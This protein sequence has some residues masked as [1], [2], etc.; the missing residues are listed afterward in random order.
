MKRISWSPRSLDDLEAL[1]EFIADDSPQNTELVRCRILKAVD[2][3]TGFQFGQEGPIPG[4][5][6]LYIQKTSYFLIYRFKGENE[7]EVVAFY[8]SSRDWLQEN[9]EE[10]N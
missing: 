7:L 9:M 1:L 10:E 8:H 4:T 3:L 6:R 5:Y 2:L